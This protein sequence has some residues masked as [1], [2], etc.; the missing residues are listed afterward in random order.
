M[1]FAKDLIGLKFGRLQV[2]SRNYEAQDEHYKNTGYQKAFWNCICDCGNTAI[3]SSCALNN[4][5]SP[6]RSCGCYKK[7]RI[8]AQK[9][10]KDIKWVTD[11]NITYGITNNGDKFLIDT[12]DFDKVKGYCWRKERKGYIVANNRNGSNRIVWIHRIIMCANDDEI[13][14][15]INWDKSDNRKCNLRIA[16]KTQN[17]INIKRKSNNTSGYTGVSV[18][19]NG[20]FHS[21]ISYG[22]IKYH[23]GT[24]D[25]IDDA[26]KVRHEA[27][28]VL[29]GEWSGEI[30]RKDFRHFVNSK[31]KK[32]VT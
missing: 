30:N 10:T 12:E 9:N 18:L 3:V 16:T 6:T 28:K 19:R 7:E 31:V 14:D 22:G 2:V 32:E 11:G 21:A 24:F 17:N 4:K 23:L 13:V 29:H 15:H 26:A 1:S 25:N 27:E 20:K 8:H 5:T